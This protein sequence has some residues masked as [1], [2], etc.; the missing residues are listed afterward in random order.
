[1]G[2]AEVESVGEHLTLV[3]ARLVYN[4]APGAGVGLDDA[5][6][7]PGRERS[8]LPDFDPPQLRAFAEQVDLL[9]ASGASDVAGREGRQ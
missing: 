4:D 5:Q 1:V 8:A 6:A 7:V 9:G 2:V 3:R